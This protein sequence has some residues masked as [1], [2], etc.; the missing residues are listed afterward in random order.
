MRGPI[1]FFLAVASVAACYAGGSGGPDASAG[2]VTFH[3]DVEPILQKVCQNC[4]VQGGIAP[5]PLLT[6]ADA[7]ANA[8]GM[9]AD[10][11]ARIMPPFGARSTPEC[12]PRYPW[13]GDWSLTDAEIATIKAWHDGGDLEGDPKDAPPPV[14]TPPVT[15][16][17]NATSLAP[18]V[19]YS[20][21]PNAT[22]D[23]FRCFVLDP[24]LAATTY[25]T[26][27]F[28]KPGNRTI[29]HHALI[30]AVPAG[31]TIPPPDDPNVPDQYTCFGSS[32]VAGEQLVAAWAPGGQPYVYPDGV[33]HPLDPGTKF[34][35]QI[36]YHPHANAVFDPDTTTF[37]FST[38]DQKPAWTVGTALLGNYASAV[39]SGG[40]GLQNPPFL[41]VPDAANQVFT[42][43]FTMPALYPQV[44]V[45]AVASHMHL[46]GSDQKITLTRQSPQSGDPQSECLIQ[47]PRWD[48]NWQRAYE[49]DTDIASLPLISPGDV[50]TI[51][52]TYDNT[53][54]NAALVSALTEEGLKQTQPVSLGDT[55]M[56][57]MCL[58]A[59]WYVYPTP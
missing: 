2:G 54:N 6:Y 18:A 11:S 24:Q 33:A 58:G 19:P 34:I 36:H 15:D 31:S 29:V 48:F 43:Q 50:L 53:M 35:M 1:S 56:D 25:L 21:P 45:L 26:G 7:K 12:Q 20:M 30:F 5:F 22:N 52:C 32:G 8:A 3:K 37:Q 10:T 14:T 41:I 17:P 28:V 44:R 46:V 13:K 55:T 42:M 27:T 47:V 4:H 51:R 57:E 23:D 9:V 49:Y 39:G 40:T 59:F 16:L 38:T